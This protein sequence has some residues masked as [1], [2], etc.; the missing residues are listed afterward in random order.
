MLIF[1]VKIKKTATKDSRFFLN[2]CYMDH[3]ISAYYC[4]INVEYV[5]FL[6]MWILVP[7]SVFY[8]FWKNKE[9]GLHSPD[10]PYFRNRLYRR[11][12]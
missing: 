12:K 3:K 10:I 4:I 1:F 6:V 2:P 8:R 5:D 11:S 7:R 9:G